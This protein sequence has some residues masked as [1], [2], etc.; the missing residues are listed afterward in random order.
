MRN[1]TTKANKQTSKQAS[2]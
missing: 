2:N 1:Q